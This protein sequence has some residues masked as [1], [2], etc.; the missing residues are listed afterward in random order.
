[1]LLDEEDVVSEEDGLHMRILNDH[2]EN[3][4]APSNGTEGILPNNRILRIGSD[5][6]YRLLHTSLNLPILKGTQDG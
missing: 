3:P 1:M 6:C 2:V 5:A 4:V